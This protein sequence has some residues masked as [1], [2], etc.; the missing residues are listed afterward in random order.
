MTPPWSNF[1]GTGTA[2]R[3]AIYTRVSSHE[4][5]LGYSLEEQVSRLRKLCSE[6][7]GRCV[8]MF[9][10]VESGGSMDRPKLR[11]LL[12]LAEM[13]AFDL[14]LVWRVDRLG[15]SNVDL[16]NIWAYLKALGIDLVSAS[17]AF[18]STTVQGKAMFD[19][20]A[21]FSEWER[22]TIRER[23]AMGAFARA[24]DGKWHGGPTPH[25]YAYEPATER[26]YVAK[27]EAEL[28]HYVAR[29]ALEKR[30]LSAVVRTLRNEGRLTK[31]KKPWSK[32][33]VSRLLGN[34]IYV[35]FLRYRDLVTR[36]E[37]LRILDD[38]M[39]AQ[40]QEL[41]MEW[42]RHRI[43]QY[44]RPRG[45]RVSVEEW[46]FKCGCALTGARAYCSN[47]GAAQWLSHVSEDDSESVTAGA[48]S[49]HSENDSV[50]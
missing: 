39:F 11:L 13:G 12:R 48:A 20:L 6:R 43:A 34:P 15:R 3:V 21:L 22:G 46:C 37:S 25:G 33:T 41:R 1:K 5:S 26:L 4:Q 8:R 44:H 18:D 2:A 50:C 23:A 9:R 7:G 35:G 47:C 17:E 32:P 31:N 28:V 42:R 29:L 24:K 27:E 30:D 19:M 40:L 45:S 10:E 36:D 14:I 49:E 16:Q 38:G